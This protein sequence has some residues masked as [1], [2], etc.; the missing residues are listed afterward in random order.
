MGYG[1]GKREYYRRQKLT[2]TVIIALALVLLLIL[3]Y[4]ILIKYEFRNTEAEEV[5]TKEVQ[6]I[7][8]DGFTYI[9]KDNIET[10]LIVGIDKYQDEIKLNSY[11]NNQQADTLIL[12]AVDKDTKKINLIQLNRDTMTYVK[13][14]GVTGETVGKVYEQLALSH[15]YG[16]GGKDSMNNTV[17]AVSELLLDTPINH[18]AC[19]S[20]DVVVEL[21][22]MLG[23]VVMNDIEMDGKEAL[24]FVRNRSNYEGDSNIDRMA[25]QRDFLKILNEKYKEKVQKDQD[26]TVEAT[27]KL[28]QYILTDLTLNQIS[29][30]AD[31]VK[32]YDMSE[33][34]TIDGE[35]KLGTEF[36]EFYIDKDDLT[37]KVIEIFYER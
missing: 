3:I 24:E 17:D 21:T 28:S 2:L 32:E 19:F 35:A 1:P 14:L 10:T 5:Y 27:S 26:F 20:M 30:L 8:Y 11:N 31:I 16:T 22:D 6:T 36:M 34:K 7:N 37:K 25:R 9:L 4:T 13:E 29:S 12:L 18:Y 15:T 23:G 33:I